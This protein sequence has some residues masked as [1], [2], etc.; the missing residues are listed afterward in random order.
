MY[1]IPQ[2]AFVAFAVAMEEESISASLKKSLSYADFEIKVAKFLDRFAAIGS[3]EF[4][5]A[6]KSNSAFKYFTLGIRP[7]REFAFTKSVDREKSFD[8]YNSGDFERT[9]LATL[10]EKFSACGYHAL[11]LHS[12][13]DSFVSEFLKSNWQNLNAL[14]DR[15]L[16]IY[17]S[18][19]T[20]NPFDEVRA[21]RELPPFS[22]L[23]VA[24]L[25]SLCVWGKNDRQCY[26][27]EG[28]RSNP[29][30]LMQLVQ[31]VVAAIEER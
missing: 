20:D 8:E 30:E 19:T 10:L 6:L 5:Y 25:P 15:Y 24:A 13:A 29:N 26:P 3:T 27:L 18:V 31:S 23:S 17:V 12:S 21:L 11:F 9:E 28:F 4:A 16:N 22:E 7:T 1:T 14:S 2:V